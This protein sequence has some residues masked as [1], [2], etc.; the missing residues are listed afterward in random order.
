MSGIVGILNRDGTPVDRQLISRMTSFLSFRGPD[1]LDVQINGN[2]AFGHAM[3]CTTVEAATEQQPLTLDQKLWLTADVRLDA[4]RELVARLEDKLGAPV[5]TLDDAPRAPNDAELILHAYAA[6]ADDC[7]KY[8][9]GD[10]AFAIWDAT[11]Q[12][13]FC[14]RD[15]LGIRQLYY[16]VSADCFVFSN[17]LHCLR[18]HPRVSNNLNE[19]AIGDFLLF[20]QNQE[21]E[22]TTFADIKR[23]P[24]AHALSVSAEG[25]RLREY[26]TP[27]ASTTRYRR[28]R[29][30]IERFQELLNAS[31]ADRLR[32][33][34]VGISLSGGLDSSAVA[35]VATQ[36][37][38]STP[39][40]LSG[41][42][43]VY[44]A[45]FVDEERKYAALVAD[46]LNIPLQLL[47]GNKINEQD[48][49]R[50][51]GVAPEPFDVE[52]LYAVSKEL[53][54]SL[55][56]SARVALTG[57]DGDTFLNETPKH[58]FV[59][60][61]KKGNVPRLLLDMTRYVYAQR[62]PPPI[63]IRTQWQRWRNPHW[64]RRPFPVWLNQEFSKRLK[65]DE[66]WRQ[67]NTEVPTAHPLRPRAFS[68]L[69]SPSWD[70]LFANYDAGTTLVPLEVRHPLIDVRMVEYLLSLPVVPWMLEKT[71]LRKAMAGTLPNA[72]L[73]RP[74]S[75]LASDPGLH[76]SH[77]KKFQSIDEFQPVA[78][79]LSYVDR[80]SIP[81]VAEEVNSNQLSI[82]VRPFSLNQWLI[83]S[84]SMEQTNGI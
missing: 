83:H 41:C 67:V 38:D 20:G 5:R 31:V 10:F 35:A 17:T 6:W 62:S 48:D 53:L 36:S 45:I 7:V 26:W 76:L 28:D 57:W 3:F 82:N 1:A 64:N 30:Y 18:L 34:R 25:V 37:R 61:L 4:R 16:S 12:R 58:S 52:P 66:R 23:L 22:T 54:R 68:T 39:L 47:E 49:G 56:S 19:L 69:N 59:A 84:L 80:T 60:S 43:V 81:R 8:L 73:S 42:C 72:V 40:E 13:L 65:L 46:A 71:I 79:L 74:K 51:V 11:Q 21:K 77:T 2:V 70:L 9:L 75:P 50:D 24:R 29:D 44:D 32:T 63:G 78:A 27:T 14:A 15:Q 55:A 33:E